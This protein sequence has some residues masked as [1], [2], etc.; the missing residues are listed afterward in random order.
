MN[1]V[2]KP[3]MVLYADGVENYE[4]P[5]KHGSTAIFFAPLAKEFGDSNRQKMNVSDKPTVRVPYADEVKLMRNRQSAEAL[6][7]FFPEP[8]AKESGDSAVKFGGPSKPNNNIWLMVMTMLVDGVGVHED[9]A[10]CRGSKFGGPAQKNVICN[11]L[12]FLLHS[13][14]P[15]P[16]FI[17]PSGIELDLDAYVNDLSPRQPT[18]RALCKDQISLITAAQSTSTSASSTKISMYTNK[19]NAISSPAKGAMASS[20]SYNSSHGD[21]NSVLPPSTLYIQ[22]GVDCKIAFDNALGKT[23]L[24]QA[25]KDAAQWSLIAPLDQLVDEE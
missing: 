19:R 2:D 10:H 7:F 20:I 6:P 9:S 18:K 5:A 16:F 17:P 25:A 14:S 13:L 11:T 15:L 22:P 3:V 21:D 12:N 8:L 4:E 23:E 24:L 1:V